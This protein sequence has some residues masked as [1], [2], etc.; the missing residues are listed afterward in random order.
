MP[1]KRYEDKIVIIAGDGDIIWSPASHQ[2]GEKVDHILFAQGVK[3]EI[4]RALPDIAGRKY[5]DW[6]VKIVLPCQKS[7]SSLNEIM[8]N[9]AIEKWGEIPNIKHHTT[10][11]TRNR[12]MK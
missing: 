10:R 8:Q 11:Y 4:G 3:G 6:S 1:I 9:Y 2:H 5:N 12:G 7:W